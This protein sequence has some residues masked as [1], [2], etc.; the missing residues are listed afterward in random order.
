MISDKLNHQEKIDKAIALMRDFKFS[1]AEN[2]AKEVL[3]E[4]DKNAK[5]MNL[6]GGIAYRTG[7]ADLA[8]LYYNNALKLSPKSSLIITNMANCFSADK[9]TYDKAEICFQKAILL[10]PECVFAY[11]EYSSLLVKKRDYNKAE[12]ILNDAPKNINDKEIYIKFLYLY[13]KIGK[14]EEV[15]K[16]AKK[17]LSVEDNIYCITMLAYLYIYTSKYQDLYQLIDRFIG[18]GKFNKVL[19][20][21]IIVCSAI[22]KYLSGDLEGAISDIDKSKEIENILSLPSPPDI[23]RA[24]W[25]TMFVYHCFL[26]SLI[27]YHKENNTYIKEGMDYI[28][29]IGDSHCLSPANTIIKYNDKDYFVKSNLILGGKI[30]HFIQEENNEY[31]SSFSNHINLIPENSKLIVMFGE[32]DCRLNEGIL[33]YLTNNSNIDMSQYIDDMV[34]KYV[35][36]ILKESSKKNLEVIFYGVPAPRKKIDL[37]NEDKEI[38]DIKI[39]NLKKI[40]ELFNNNLKENAKLSNCK[41]LDVYNYTNDINGLSSGKYHIDAHHLYP[42]ILRE[43]F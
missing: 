25:K 38:Y 4:D 14:F 40:I 21:N 28:Y 2:L 18:K 26:K 12:N 33:S 3:K 27:D 13:Q 20:S 39:E 41:F 29:A 35:D 19:E 22:A 1:E 8:L 17:I 16:Y 6:L 30:Y 5:A 42:N 32:I 23:S 37:I 24:S 7:Q 10:N 43:I 31:K 15:K 11:C 34:S 36:Y 9:S